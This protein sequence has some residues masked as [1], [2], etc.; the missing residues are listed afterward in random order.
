MEAGLRW[1]GSGSALSLSL[2][3]TKNQNDILFLSAGPGQQG[4]FANFECTRHQGLDLAASKQFGKLDMRASYNYLEAVFDAEGRLFTGARNVGV[5]PGT[6][7]AGLP[8]HT[9]KLAADWKP[10]AAFSVGGDLQAISS[11]V[12]QG[13]EDGLLANLNIRGHAVLNLRASYRFDPHW[14]LFAR[15]G[16]V[17]NRRYETY[18]AIATNV[19]EPA[20]AGHARFVAPGAPRTVAGGIR[21]N[22]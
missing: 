15:A 22:F 10:T 9:F 13:N 19:F 14:E 7:M 5:T 21:A 11:L 12:T 17:S 8:R 16:N 20:D 6:R 3:R 18:G 1:H 4:Y 2:Y